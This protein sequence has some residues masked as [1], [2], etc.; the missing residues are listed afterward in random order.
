MSAS[1][2]DFGNRPPTRCVRI[3]KVLV[4]DRDPFWGPSIKAALEDSGYYLNLVSD[5]AEG[6]RRALERAYELVI[7]GASVGPAA[8]TGILEALAHR[9]K[10]PAVIVVGEGAELKKDPDHAGLATFSVLRAPCSIEDVVDS[11][12]TMVG[13]PWTDHRM[14][15]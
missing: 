6:C 5:P 15:A 14:G 1:S 12:R 11:A 8:L 10:P 13:V 2:Q 9:P 4:I 7:L 3:R